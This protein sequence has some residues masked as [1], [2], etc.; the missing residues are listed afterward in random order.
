MIGNLNPF[1]LE[2]FGGEAVEFLGMFSE[3]S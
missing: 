1:A 2:A 3:S